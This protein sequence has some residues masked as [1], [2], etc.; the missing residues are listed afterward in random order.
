[1]REQEQKI[2]SEEINVRRAGKIQEIEAAK[3]RR[4]TLLTQVLAGKASAET[5]SIRAAM[6]GVTSRSARGAAL[7]PAYNYAREMSE[8]LFSRRP[9]Y[10]VRRGSFGLSRIQG[11]K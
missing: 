11:G 5:D 1:M 4:E 7:T 3:L 2:R 8:K 6:P 10:E 9:G